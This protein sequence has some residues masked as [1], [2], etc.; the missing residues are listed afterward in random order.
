[1][2]RIESPHY[3]NISAREHRAMIEVINIHA[4]ALTE[5]IRQAEKEGH[6]FNRELVGRPMVPANPSK[7]GS[8]PHEWRVN[9]RSID[10]VL[11][12]RILR[13]AGWPTL[14][15]TLHSLQLSDNHHLH[16][17]VDRRGALTGQ[18][19]ITL[20]E[21]IDVVFSARP[22]ISDVLANTPRLLTHLDG[23]TEQLRKVKVSAQNNQTT[24]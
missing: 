5:R 20:I 4:D 24:T 16:A 12:F 22:E 3:P 13:Y 11:T 1:M 19:P 10:D 8:V 2:S 18:P 15:D 9:F 7:A 23:A 14:T 17:R 21:P 6:F